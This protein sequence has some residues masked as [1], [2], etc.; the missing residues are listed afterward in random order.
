[1]AITVW[2][3]YG[4]EQTGIE[5]SESLYTDKIEQEILKKGYSKGIDGFYLRGYQ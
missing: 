3:P 5:F 1:M 2:I 4:N